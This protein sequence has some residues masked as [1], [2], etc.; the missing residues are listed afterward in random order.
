MHAYKLNRRSSP[1]N[2]SS[3]IFLIATFMPHQYRARLVDCG[4]KMCVTVSIV[5]LR[6]LSFGTIDLHWW[7]PC[8]DK[9]ANRQ[10]MQERGAPGMSIGD[11]QL[12]GTRLS[13][14]EA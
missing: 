4:I 8:E 3:T 9:I 12:Q 14:P 6:S 5:S 13:M 7:Q 1:E 10:G 2:N 11:P